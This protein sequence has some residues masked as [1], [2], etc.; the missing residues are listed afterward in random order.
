MVYVK[1][2]HL[3]LTAADNHNACDLE[4][5]EL[6]LI[7]D[8]NELPTGDKTL[9]ALLGAPPLTP[10]LIYPPDQEEEHNHGLL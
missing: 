7:I 6:R 3:P 2:L 8:S 4:D 1:L 9:D 5:T 10:M